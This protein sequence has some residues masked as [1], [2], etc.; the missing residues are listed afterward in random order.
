MTNSC[1]VDLYFLPPTA[2][3]K[4][5]LSFETVEIETE[6]HFVKQTYRNRCH[7]LGANGIQAIT[8][9][10]DKSKKKQY[11]K[12]V[13][14]NYTE[15]WISKNNTTLK[16]AYANSPFFDHYH[17]YFQDI[18]MKKYDFLYDLNFELMNLC[19]KILQEERI[20]FKTSSFNLTYKGEMDFREVHTN[21]KKQINDWSHDDITSY[22]QVFGKEFVPN[23]SII[24]LIFCEGPMA[25]NY[26][27]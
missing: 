25:I 15:N 8:I 24:D 18:I 19:L 22:Q 26:L 5:I 10:V 13:K 23:L 2:F 9:P 16:S 17:V 4:E 3:F 1:L 7:V 11:Y 6:S 20:I 14:I 27:V 21:K 12:D